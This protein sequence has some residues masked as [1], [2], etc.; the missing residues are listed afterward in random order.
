M[1]DI[2]IKATFETVYMVFFSSLFAVILGG[3]LGVILVSTDKNGQYENKF[4]YSILSFMINIFRSVPF[5]ILIIYIL[6]VSKILI[7]KSIGSTAAIIPLTVSAIPFVARI[8]ESALKDVDT[9]IVEAGKSMGATKLRVIRIMIS[10]SLPQLVN[11]ITLTII[12][13]IG[14]SAMAGA[15]GAKGLGDL[16]ITYGL[17]R[18]QYGAMTIPVIII[19]ILVQLVQITGDFVSKKINK[20]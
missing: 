19:V 11:G 12:N 20:K 18:F 1:K 8:F 2:L 9:G 5:L 6:P 13:L 10:E 14:Y 3:L 16:A 15:I 4:I 7:G 17:Y